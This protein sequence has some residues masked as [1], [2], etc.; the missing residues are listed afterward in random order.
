MPAERREAA[1]VHVLDREDGGARL[2]VEE[3]HRVVVR[4][5]HEQVLLVRV[6]VRLWLRLRLR[7]RVRVRV[8]VS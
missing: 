4:G 8:R 3:A 1:L 5:A 7:V 6:R 2:R